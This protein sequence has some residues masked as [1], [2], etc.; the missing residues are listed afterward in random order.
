MR[1]RHD[2]PVGDG[3][4]RGD[5]PDIRHPAARPAAVIVQRLGLL[6]VFLRGHGAGLAQDFQLGQAP[7]N[8]VFG[9]LAAGD[10]WQCDGRVR[11]SGSSN[12]QIDH[13]AVRYRPVAHRPARRVARRVGVQL[14]RTSS[15]KSCHCAIISPGMPRVSGDRSGNETSSTSLPVGGTEARGQRHRR[16]APAFR[17]GEIPRV[18]PDRGQFLRQQRVR[19]EIAGPV[20]A[21]AVADDRKHQVGARTVAGGSPTRRWSAA[22]WC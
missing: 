21:G 6:G 13:R 11:R 22:R 15:S 9:G 16:Q 18:V 17:R 1:D 20:P 3:L 5:H 7:R 12:P 8:K 19:H 10:L 4:H 2:H 14:W